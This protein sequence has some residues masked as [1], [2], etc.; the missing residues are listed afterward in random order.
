VTVR[1]E[2]GR[3]R[4]LLVT[5]VLFTALAW[6][7]GVA[8]AVLAG[9][10]L[11]DATV[12]LPGGLPAGAV[13]L[14]SVAGA[15]AFALRAWRARGVV[16]L[17]D[18]ALWVESRVPDL[19]YALVTA[20]DPRA[21]V[22]REVAA[23]LAAHPWR[24]RATRGL[25][26]AL[27]PPLALV[28]AALAAIAVLPR[29]S[30]ARIAARGPDAGAGT[31]GAPVNRLASVVA[32][33]TPPLYANRRPQRVADPASLAGLEGS[34]IL[35]E[36]R[37]GT[38]GLAARLGDSALT[39]AAAGPRWRVALVM[40]RLPAAIRLADSAASRVIV[41]EPQPDSLPVVT[42]TAPLRDTVLRLPPRGALRLTADVHD[43][44]GLSAFRFEVIVSSG[45]METFT[46]R[47]TVVG[48]DS[49][50]GARDA[51]RE[52]VLPLDSL[53]LQPGDVVHLRAVASDVRAPWPGRGASE[54]RTWRVIRTGEYD[55]LA[56]EGAPPTEGDTSLISQRM[57]ILMAEALERRR[58]RLERPPVLRE[59]REIARDQARL[60]RRVADIVFMRL[61]EEPSGE[62]VEGMDERPR[63][64]EEVLRAAEEAATRA[65]AGEP[66]DFAG[67]ETPIVAINRPLLEAYN[68]MWDAVRELE[69]GEPDD[70]L[71]HMRVALA[72]IQRARLAERIYLRGRPPRVVV[73]LRRVRLIGDVATAAPAGRGPRE[74]GRGGR[75]ELAAR[76]ERAVALV[77]AGQ[78]AAAVDSLQLLRVDALAAA[79]EAA[80]VLAA[81]VRALRG[82]GDVSALLLAARR[83]LSGEAMRARGGLPAWS[84]AW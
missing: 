27:V 78:G 43:D 77:I 14:A 56:I 66:T 47:A 11:F 6:T 25:W 24:R 9:L 44:I 16:R 70:A 72:A 65:T 53:A 1:A 18:V 48:A 32:T 51:T 38:E 33:V 10:V 7:L 71:P 12:G 13:L 41:L 8:L 15:G 81:A 3:T 4:A 59:S 17:S 5:L 22:G 75:A 61:G 46:S 63:T 69:L 60:R 39:V 68:A 35:L 21:R 30:V 2:L 49:L 80:V 20:A 42:L 29:S 26:R 57:L 83:R 82:G 50:R 52:A 19:A 31:A 34:T 54:T 55:S 64:P 28:A 40:P 36:G 58:P 45:E 67:D 79:P 73:D 23:Q 37:G 76:F 84:E 74:P 62:E